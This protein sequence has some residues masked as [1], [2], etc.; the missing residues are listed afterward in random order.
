ML[1]R[2]I[3][4]ASEI[5]D[6]A[7]N[8][9]GEII[10]TKSTNSSRNNK[11]RAYL[12]PRRPNF[13]SVTNSIFAK[14]DSMIVYSGPIEDTH[15]LI[16]FFR[17]EAPKLRILRRLIVTPEKTVVLDVNRDG[18]EFPGLTFDSPA[19]ERLLDDLGVVYSRESLSEAGGVKEFGLGAVWT[20]GHDSV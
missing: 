14:L 6:T 4:V 16:Q 3:L 1:R 12:T 7:S 11:H 5:R 8:L 10:A 9:C 15:R 19:L 2:N 18:I 13:L 17:R 20:W